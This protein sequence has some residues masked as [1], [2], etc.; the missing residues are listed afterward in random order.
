VLTAV[1]ALPATL[2]LRSQLWR[3]PEGGCPTCGR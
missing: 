1:T 3:D 2:W